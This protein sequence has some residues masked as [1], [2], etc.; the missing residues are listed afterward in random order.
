MIESL[1]LAYE[2]Q[3]PRRPSHLARRTTPP[4]ERPA[5]PNLRYLLYVGLA[6]TAVVVALAV[7][8]II[9]YLIQLVTG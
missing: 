6:L 9:G 2:H 8:Y 7:P 4:P 5:P 3:R 1:P